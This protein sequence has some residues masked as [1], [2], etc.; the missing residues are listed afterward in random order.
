MHRYYLFVRTLA[1]IAQRCHNITVLLH[2]TYT[3]KN[4][5]YNKTQRNLFRLRLLVSNLNMCPG[6]LTR[7]QNQPTKQNS[8]LKLLYWESY[9]YSISK[10]E[11]IKILC[12][13][14]RLVIQLS[15][16]TIEIDDS[17][18]DAINFQLDKTYISAASSCNICKKIY[19][20]ILIQLSYNYYLEEGNAGNV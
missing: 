12:G 20:F 11:G 17:Q 6:E 13:M 10:Y 14:R 8:S 9:F 19:I 2:T 1:F 4:A 16:S 15:N 5:F 7:Y 3:I 18:W